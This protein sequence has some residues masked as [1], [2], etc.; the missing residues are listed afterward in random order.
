M[1]ELLSDHLAIRGLERIAVLLCSL[2]L[3][4]LGFLLVVSGVHHGLSRSGSE[5]K[6]FRTPFPG[7]GPGL[8]FMGAGAVMFVAVLMTGRAQL[9]AE[10]AGVDV[11][12]ERTSRSYLDALGDRCGA[13]AYIRPNANPMH[14]PIGPDA[15]SHV[16]PIT[17]AR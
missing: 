9:L 6:W 5:A 11:Y 1:R 14:G 17:A 10:K 3:I 15:Q 2:T 8:L 13:R 12:A 4:W 7:P 16:A